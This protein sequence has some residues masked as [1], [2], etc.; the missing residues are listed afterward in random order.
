VFGIIMARSQHQLGLLLVAAA[1]IAWSTA[2]YFIRQLPY[3]SWTILFWRGIFGT[4]LIAMFLL[5]TQG[6]TLLSDFQR[7]GASGWLVATLSTIGMTAFVP[8]LQFTSVANVAV[9]NAT[10]PFVTA[11][12]AWLWLRE[13]S[14]PRTLIASAVALCG[15]AVIVGGVRGG[16]DIRGIALAGVMTVAIAAMTVVVR[17]NREIPMAGASAL[18]IMLGSLVSLPFAQSIANVTSGD[19]VTLVGF[20]FQIA[21]GLTLFIVGSRLLPSGQAALIATLETPLMPFWIW[22]AFSDVPA[23][24]QLLGGAL[25][26]GAVIADILL[27]LRQGAAASCPLPAMPPAN[28][29]S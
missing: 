5:G 26:L 11:G 8:A 19:L 18:S 15:V 22:L 12:L 28:V 25:V 14:K 24:H 6:R 20:G 7:M 13:P 27:D 21:I 1:A 4:A 17:R 23:L 10:A 29:P 16:S 3:D 9:I 2:P